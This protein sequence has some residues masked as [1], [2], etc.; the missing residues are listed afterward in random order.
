MRDDPH[1]KFNC[2]LGFRT[3]NEQAKMADSDLA[4][5]MEDVAMAMKLYMADELDL[6]MGRPP[7]VDS[8]EPTK[9]DHNYQFLLRL[10][11]NSSM[12]STKSLT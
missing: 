7:D 9:M 4:T 3:L 10:F 1:Y 11:S 5:T 2:S 12:I 6:T 8:D